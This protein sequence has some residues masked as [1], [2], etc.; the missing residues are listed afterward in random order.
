MLTITVGVTLQGFGRLALARVY[1]K[2]ERAINEVQNR[3][4]VQ[5]ADRDRSG[6]RDNRD[7]GATE[8]DDERRSLLKLNG[9]SSSIGN[10]FFQGEFLANTGHRRQACRNIESLTGGKRLLGLPHR[11]SCALAL[12]P[13]E[14][15]IAGCSVA[16]T[17]SSC[18]WSPFTKHEIHS[19]VAYQRASSSS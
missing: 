3:A 18:R 2:T 1:M 5:V 15:A 12:G 10:T 7:G 16:Y 9:S 11:I 19:R 8:D 13:S 4:R 6:S 14:Y 17:K